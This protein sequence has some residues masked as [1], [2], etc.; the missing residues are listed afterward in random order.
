MLP[1]FRVPDE[2][3]DRIVALGKVFRE[4]KR[5]EV[6]TLQRELLKSRIGVTRKSG[7]TNLSA[8][9]MTSA[10]L[11]HSQVS[12]HDWSQ[13]TSTVISRIYYI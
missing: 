10:F 9:A 13:A 7:P 11:F 12:G 5:A 6:V 1:L 3:A 2:A 8:N 4:E